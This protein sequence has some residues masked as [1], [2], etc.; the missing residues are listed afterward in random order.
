MDPE[1]PLVSMQNGEVCYATQ[2]G[3]EFEF[4]TDEY[5]N[6]CY[7]I[8]PSRSG[9]Q[10]QGPNGCAHQKIQGKWGEWPGSTPPARSEFGVTPGTEGD[11]DVWWVASMLFQ[12]VT[13]RSDS[14]LWL[15][16]QRWQGVDQYTLLGRFTEMHTYRSALCTSLFNDYIWDL[17]SLVTEII[18]L[19]F[20]D[21]TKMLLYQDQDF[22]E[23]MFPLLVFRPHTIFAFCLLCRDWRDPVQNWNWDHQE[24]SSA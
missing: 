7:F 16:R 4:S 11:G 10:G 1:A 20:C 6:Y 3:L 21:A 19:F 15:W 22:A 9:C 23:N 2:C 14:S 13:C 5:I 12:N 17:S 24:R 8:S 18:P